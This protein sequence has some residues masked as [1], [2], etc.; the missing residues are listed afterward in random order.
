LSTVK[1]RT[2]EELLI[3]ILDPS[4]EVNPQYVAVRIKTTSDQILDGLIASENATSVTLKRQEGLT[5]T[6]LK[7]NI[8]KLV[9]STLSLMPEG[10]EKIVDP[11]AMADLIQFLKQ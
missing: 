9:R 5:D 10:F 7:V 1:Q 2:P 3:A 11:Q 6:I 8:D 4:R